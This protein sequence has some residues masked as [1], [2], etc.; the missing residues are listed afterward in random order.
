[1]LIPQTV[2]TSSKITKG[3]FYTFLE[4]YV[5]TGVLTSK[6]AK[7]IERRAI[8]SPCFHVRMLNQFFPTF[9]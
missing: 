5:G 9:K 1:M 3:F 8:I 4:P 7:W 6:G 2:L